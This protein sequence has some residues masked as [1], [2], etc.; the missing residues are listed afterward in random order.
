GHMNRLLT[1]FP[2]TASVRTKLHNKGFQT[3]GDVLEL[4]PTEL[5][6]E[7]EICKEEALEIIKFLEEETQKVK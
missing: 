7:L 2:L 6:A 3:V 5:S 4:K 1:S